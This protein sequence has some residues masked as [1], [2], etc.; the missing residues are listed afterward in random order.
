MAWR[1]TVGVNLGK[2][3]LGVCRGFADAN[4]PFQIEGIPAS[5]RIIFTRAARLTAP[6]KNQVESSP[7]VESLTEEQVP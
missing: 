2:A 1:Y 5:G 7:I 6:Q 4:R 3:L